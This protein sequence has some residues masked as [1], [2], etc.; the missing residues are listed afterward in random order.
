MKSR[1][2]LLVCA[3]VLVTFTTIYSLQYVRSLSIRANQVTYHKTSQLEVLQSQGTLSY[4]E[5]VRKLLKALRGATASSA[6]KAAVHYVAAYD[7]KQLEID[8][9]EQAAMIKEMP[10]SKVLEATTK[11]NSA[12]THF[13]GSLLLLI[14]ETAPIVKGI[15]DDLHYAAA[16]DQNKFPNREGRIMLYGGHLRE[17]YQSE[18]VRT[19]E[20]LSNYLRLL[21]EEVDAL[22]SSH[23]SFINKM[24]LT[25]PRDVLEHSKVTGYMQGDGIVFLAGGRFN[26]LALVSIKMLRDL[27]SKLP[28]EVVI[29]DWNALDARFC[30]DGLPS[31]GASCKVLDHF[32]GLDVAGR[33]KSYQLK[34]LALLILSFQRVLYLDA[35]NIVI[36]NP[37]LLFVNEP[38]I[39]TGFVLWPDLWR[40]STS[41]S[42]YDIAE[43]SVNAKKRVRNSY[44]KD[45]PKGTQ[46]PPSLHDCEGAIP[47]ASSETGQIL[48]DKKKHFSALVLAMYYNYHG[49]DY[50]YPLLSQGAAGEGDKETFVAA[51]HKLELPYYQVQE[52]NREFGPMT[53]LKQ[54]HPF[55]MGQYDPILDFIQSQNGEG[56]YLGD[57]LFALRD[58]PTCGTSDTDSETNNYHFHLYEASSLMFLHANWPKLYFAE[59]LLQNG[60]GRGPMENGVRRRLYGPELKAEAGYDLEL[61]ISQAMNWCYCVM[62]VDLHDVP[63]VGLDDRKAGCKL[64][65]QHLKFLKEN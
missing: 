61:A 3:L 17:N 25:V 59:L 27:G 9:Q 1:R 53:E 19:T 24:P 20:M 42:F 35:D 18:P 34:N 28:I 62:N 29:K 60:I 41:P 48:I 65:R 43:I 12:L 26:Q 7:Y 49:F 4:D 55:G 16:R 58:T 15:N 11:F 36:K 56:R 38:F 64:L 57:S 50:Y 33:V 10:A 39:S 44:F 2:Q 32:L 8:Q 47:E 31:L 54:H 63:S 23:D 21:T 52:F 14:L 40:R 51:A 13:L 30:E 45:D 22:R 5:L 6:K 46:D 37:D